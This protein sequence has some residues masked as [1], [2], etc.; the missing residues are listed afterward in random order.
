MSRITDKNMNALGALL[1]AIITCFALLGCSKTEPPTNSN[2]NIHVLY[3][4]CYSGKNVV[5]ENEIYSHFMTQKE[6]I[7]IAKDINTTYLFDTEV[8][9]YVK[10][11]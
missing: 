1:L 9:C 10:K 5:F 8:P 7:I 6:D 3:V 11:R 2:K 4:K